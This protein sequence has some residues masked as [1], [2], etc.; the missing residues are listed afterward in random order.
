MSA[1]SRPVLLLL[2][3]LLLFTTSMAVLNTLVPLWLIH[4]SLT[5]WQV[6][7]VSSSYFGGNLLGTLVAGFC[8]ST[9]GFNRTYYYSCALF[10][11]A[12]LLLGLSV[13]FVSWS[14]WRLLAGIAC[15]II[16]VVVESALLRSGTIHTR[17]FLLA[18][19]MV[20]YY[21]GTLVG[22]LLLGMIPTNLSAI[23]P[24]VIGLLLLAI[25][26]LLFARFPKPE[27]ANKKISVWMMWKRRDAHLGII[28]CIISGIVIGSLY[29]LL[30]IYLSHAGYRDADVGYWIALMVG[31][32][33]I[34][35]LP[36]GKL[37]ERY[38][39]V[40]VLRIQVV[41]IIVSSM[42]IISGYPLAPALFI[43]GFSGFTLYPVA[44]AWACEKVDTSELIT[45][46]QTLLLSYTVG[47]LAGPALTAALMQHYSDRL[48]FIV[49]AVAAAI[50]MIMLFNRALRHRNPLAMQ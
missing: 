16:W 3:G 30:P 34:G 1:F 31:A 15:A 38:G 45:M 26:P 9:F 32:G 29:G 46:N 47:S 20:I 12:T 17:G 50:F 37:V 21:A 5:T 23:L 24:W 27:H 10:I 28:G 7:I 18:A 44:M 33:I 19:Y 36:A 39:R 49:I 43:L 6:G 42:V 22:Q 2:A 4:E 35:Q 48:L 14:L 25:L 41:A 13:D 40:F 11:A 8:I